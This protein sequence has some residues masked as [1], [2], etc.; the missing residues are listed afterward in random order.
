MFKIVNQSGHTAY[1]L[2]EYVCDNE[3]DISSLSID[4]TPGSTAFVISN[5]KVFMM[6]NQHQWIDISSPFSSNSSGST[7]SEFIDYTENFNEL[8]EKVAT[9]IVDNAVLK[10]QINDL[11][12]KN[13]TLSDN[14]ELLNNN[15]NQLIS[16]IVLLLEENKILSNSVNV[17]TQEIQNLKIEI[18]ALKESHEE[19]KDGGEIYVEGTMNMDKIP[20][21]INEETNTLKIDASNSEIKGNTLVIK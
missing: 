1:G 15:N 9:L 21:E 20:V 13:Q 3:S 2:K 7:S 6:N 5:Q 18:E 16:N 10:T 19:D 12:A 8:K 4:D 14:I 11:T 17:L